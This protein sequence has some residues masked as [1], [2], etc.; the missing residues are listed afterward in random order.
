MRDLASLC[1]AVALSACGGGGTGD[2]DDDAPLDAA[3]AE[4]TEA[5]DECTGETVCLDGA[6]V[7]AFGRY[8]EVRDV[9]VSLPAR[10]PDGQEW[11]EDRTPPDVFIEVSSS[12]ALAPSS[13]TEQDSSYAEFPG[14][15]RVLPLAGG[16][17]EVVAYDEDETSDALA[18]TCRIEP[19][20]VEIIRVRSIA[21][22][23]GSGDVELSVHPLDET[24]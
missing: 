23:G 5:L 11:D 4:C 7:P 1:L 22:E 9:S 10:D 16:F 6:C 24:P 20:T 19:L 3:A 8:Y 2:D 21:C 15:F 13:S 18:T 17:L 12:G 14:P